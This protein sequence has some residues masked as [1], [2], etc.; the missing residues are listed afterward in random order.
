M[1]VLSKETDWSRAADK[2]FL[3]EELNQTPPQ[4]F[5]QLARG[6]SFLSSA[7]ASRSVTAH[8][9]TTD[10]NQRLKATTY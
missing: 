7:S 3:T 10:L 4:E 5:S 8:L 1:N 2:S 6:G 9:H